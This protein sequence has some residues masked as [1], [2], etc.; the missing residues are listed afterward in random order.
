MKK[1]NLLLVV[2]SLLVAF[3]CNKDDEKPKLSNLT[4]ANANEELVVE[5]TKTYEFT[6][7]PEAIAKPAVTWT[8]T[9][10]AIAT[11]SETGEV[12][13]LSVGTAKIMVVSTTDETIKAQFELTVKPIAVTEI[14]L[15]ETSG[16]LVVGND[17][18]LTATI[19]PANATNKTLTWTSSD[20]EIADVDDGVVNANKV[21]TVTITAAKDG[22]EATYTL[23]VKPIVVTSVT[24]TPHSPAILIGGTYQMEFE[25]LPAN[26]ADKS[27]VWASTKPEVA[28]I[29]QNGVVT[30]K[31]TGQTEISATSSNGIVGKTNVS[32]K[33][34][35]PPPPPPPPPPGVVA[36]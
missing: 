15:D 9:D 30:I 14:T 13:A 20:N 29:D 35:A 36:K 21:G 5:Q 33:P 1:L 28:T 3:S 26:A 17:L 16:V 12:K 11:V 6:W 34:I 25:V 19:L 22:V 23:E 8:S 31:G 7:A 24:L 18:T 10:E 27:L 2:F 32:G 4:F